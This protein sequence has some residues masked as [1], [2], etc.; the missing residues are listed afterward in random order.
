MLFSVEDALNKAQSLQQSGQFS[1]AHDLL[2][3]A[4]LKCPVNPLIAQALVNLMLDQ[5]GIDAA[6][7]KLKS[8]LTVSNQPHTI[9]NQIGILYSN[10]GRH[11]D[12]SHFFSQAVRANPAYAPAHSNLGNAC[13]ALGDGQRALASHRQAVALDPH[14]PELLYNLGLALLESGAFDEAEAALR[15]ALKLKPHEFTIQNDLGV[16]LCRTGRP[17]EAVT[18]LCQTTAKHPNMPQGWVNLG[19]AYIDAGMPAMGLEA[20]ERALQLDSDCLPAQ[21]GQLHYRKQTRESALIPYL[22]RRMDDPTEPA[23]SRVSAAFG[24]GKALLDCDCA[25]EAFAAYAAGNARHASLHPPAPDHA[26]RLQTLRQLDHQHFAQFTLG[27]QESYR[28]SRMPVLI[29]G[30]PRSGKSLCESLLSGHPSVHAAGELNSL[31]SLVKTLFR[32]AQESHLADPVWRHASAEKLIESMPGASDTTRVTYTL[33]GHLWML[34]QL[35]ALLP[36]APIVYCRRAPADLAIANY[37]KHFANGN[38]FSYRMDT[39]GREVRQFHSL[40]EHWLSVLPNPSVVVDYEDLVA[41]PDAVAQRLCTHVGLPWS[42]E[43]LLGLQQEHSYIHALGPAGSIDAPGPIRKDF[44]GLSE[45]FSHHLHDFNQAMEGSDRIVPD[46]ESSL[47]LINE[48][49][50]KGNVHGTM[51]M[52]K[53]MNEQYPGDLALQTLYARACSLL[54]RDSEAIALFEQILSQVDLSSPSTIGFKR[55]YIEALLRA[56]Q[57]QAAEA[58]LS[59]L[60][61]PESVHDRLR[62]KLALTSQLNMPELTQFALEHLQ[63]SGAQ[64]AEALSIYA[65][66]DQTPQSISLHKRALELAPNAQRWLRLADKLEGEA[67][68][69]ALWEAAQ[70][71]PLSRFSVT[72]YAQLR[73]QLAITHPALGQLHEELHHLWSAYREDQLAQS[74]GDFGLPYQ[75]LESIRMPGSRPTA[76]RLNTYG[77][78]RLIAPRARA[79]DIGCNHGFLLLGLADQLSSGLGFDISQTCIAVGQTVAKALGKEHIDLRHQTYQAFID[80]QE[81][82][83]DLIIACA[84]HRWIEMPLP[85]FGKTLHSLLNPGGLVLIESQGRRS[86]ERIEAGFDETVTALAGDHFKL[87]HRGTICDDQINLRAFFILQRLSKCSV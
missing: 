81:S 17:N 73:K 82:G 19:H 67:R 33:P 44:V 29:V 54:G 28:D 23:P 74:F 48:Q 12:S 21:T 25:E 38:L 45:L 68:C 50:D 59:R 10:V 47:R 80:S 26:N 31:Q 4:K 22:R 78:H 60:T 75:S 24:L 34:H 83:F 72:A 53:Q 71:K 58:A 87:L 39:L 65:S 57:L 35:A 6:I 56:H 63:K 5:Q 55:E 27:L 36:Q 16:V 69:A 32:N 52:L 41:N 79:L 86:T 76:F 15:A 51:S 85:V 46:R 61:L 49:L 20:Y 30:M 66:F 18:L 42:D 84:V 70:Y 7:A 9:L 2:H 3:E 11:A 64:D 40:L 8:E 43:C 77:I 14:Q 62:L 37:F 13:K 1:A